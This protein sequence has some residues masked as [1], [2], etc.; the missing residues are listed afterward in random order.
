MASVKQS[1]SAG[2]EKSQTVRYGFFRY[3][4]LLMLLSFG[5]WAFETLLMRIIYGGFYDR[6]FMTLPFCPI[7]GVSLLTMYFLAGTPDEG[8]GILQNVQGKAARYLLY[9][10]I[11]FLVPSIAELIVGLFFDKGFGVWLWD[12]SHQPLNLWGYVCLP[13]S[14]AWAMLI[15]FFMKFVFPFCKRIIGKIPTPL[16]RILGVLLLFVTAADLVYNFLHI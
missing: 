13:V 15:F 10:L 1:T 8:R 12:Y 9:V 3:F 5:G 4:T 2:N 16:I 6:G 7:Y 11:A 14:V